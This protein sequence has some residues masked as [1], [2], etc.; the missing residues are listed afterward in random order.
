[1]TR[2]IALLEVDSEQTSARFASVS[3]KLEEASKH[4]EESERLVNIDD[5]SSS[6]FLNMSM[7]TISKAIKYRQSILLA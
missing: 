1:M 7:P 5:A 3:E 4:A 6:A 2:R